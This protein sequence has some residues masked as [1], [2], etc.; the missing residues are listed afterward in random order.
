MVEWVEQ[1]GE[2]W[3]LY[4]NQGNTAA[5][6][7]PDNPLRQCRAPSVLAT[8]RVTRQALRMAEY[9]GFANARITPALVDKDSLK[10]VPGL[11]VR[12]HDDDYRT[13]EYEGEEVHLL[14]AGRD[15]DDDEAEEYNV[16]KVR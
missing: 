12:P 1:E 13:V 4:R 14:V 2:E 9:L 11:W 3:M 16:A 5:L 7:T 6:I 15:V 10:T 8:V